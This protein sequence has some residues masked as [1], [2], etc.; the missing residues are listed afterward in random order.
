METLQ[1]KKEI[2]LAAIEVHGWKKNSENLTYQAAVSTFSSDAPS[3]SPLFTHPYLKVGSQQHPNS[4]VNKVIRVM[5]DIL[6][7]EYITGE[8]RKSR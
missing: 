6:G 4:G 1:E 8:Y 2:L 3:A 7:G 5:E